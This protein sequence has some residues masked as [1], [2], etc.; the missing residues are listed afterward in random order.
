MSLKIVES[1][2]ERVTEVVGAP[3]SGGVGCE[4]ERAH[5]ELRNSGSKG[6][7]S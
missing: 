1:G 3:C 4:S 5:S 2:V 7:E 6:F